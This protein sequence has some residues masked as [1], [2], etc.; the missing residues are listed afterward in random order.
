M[1][2]IRCLETADV[3]EALRLL[4]DAYARQRK[5]SPMLP[6]T[7]MRDAALAA[8]SIREAV[9]N[10]AVGALRSGCLIGYMGISATFGFKGQRAVLVNELSHAAEAAEVQEVYSALYEALGSQ[11]PMATSGLHIVAHFSGEQALAARLYSLGFGQFLAEEVRD[12]SEVPAGSAASGVRLLVDLDR[13]RDLEA[14]HRRYYRRSP[15]YVWKDDSPDSVR[16]GLE[17]WEGPE[18]AVFAYAEHDSPLGYFAVSA[19]TGLDEGRILRKTN[20]AQILSAYVTDAARGRGVGKAL[21]NRCI[22]WARERGFE[23]IMVEHET[24]NLFGSAFWGRYFRPYLHCVMRYAE[25]RAP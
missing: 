2:E 1:I 20:S 17:E 16:A 6:E 15:I 19:C 5:L 24:A 7:I 18:T 9:A 3:P 4:Q 25:V 22:L 13:L 23:R 14:E 10:G 21:L 11:P 12:L 8:P